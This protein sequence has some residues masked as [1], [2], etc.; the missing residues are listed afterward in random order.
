MSD[1]NESVNTNTLSEEPNGTV[2][3]TNDVIATIVGLATA[4]IEGV[5]C[6]NGGL[7]DNI[8]GLL[9][10]KNL[11]KGIKVEVGKEEV[12]IDL[13]ISVKYGVNIPNVCQN[14]QQSVTKAIETMTGLRVVEL[15]IAVTGLVLDDEESKKL[16]QSAN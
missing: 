10:K 13:S 15:N 11:A 3:F 16:P 1:Y 7:V 9:G 5:A 6:M 4:D 8:A 12:A 2:S 14:I